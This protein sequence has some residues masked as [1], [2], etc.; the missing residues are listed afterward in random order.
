MR[1]EITGCATDVFSLA[2]IQN[3]LRESGAIRV[4][5]RHAFGWRNQPQVATFA[6]VNENAAKIICDAAR[7]RLR[8]GSLPAL[9]PTQYGKE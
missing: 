8:Y 6:A 7:K 3:A 2:D 5:S 1:F 9:I 4:S